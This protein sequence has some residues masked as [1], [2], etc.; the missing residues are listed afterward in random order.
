MGKVKA[1]LVAVSQY[2]INGCSQLPLCRNDLYA[3]R[4]ALIDGINVEPE[5]ILLCGE[6]GIVSVNDLAKII[7]VSMSDMT[8]EDTY[9]FYFSGHG[10]KNFLCLTKELIDLQDFLSH[11]ENVPV[12]NKI[13]IIDSCHSGGFQLDKTPEINIQE[14]IEQFA[15]HGFAV[16]AACGAEEYSG[17]NPNRMISLYT[18]FVCDALMSHS[19][20]R[21]GHKS[22]ESINEAVVRFAEIHNHKEM[23]KPAKDRRIQNPIFRSGIGGTIF[24]DVEKYN[25]YQVEKIYKETDNYIIYSVKPLHSSIA[26]RLAVQVILRYQCTIEQITKIAIE[27]KNIISNCKVYQNKKTEDIYKDKPVNIIF[28]NFGYDEEDVINSNF[29]YNVT[30]ADETQDKNWWYRTGSDT[31]IK[32]DICIQTNTSYQLIKKMQQSDMNDEEFIKLTHEYTINIIQAA[33]QYIKIFREFTNRVISEGELITKGIPLN[34]KISDLFFMNNDLPVAPAHLHD[35][36]Q[37]HDEIISSIHNFSLFYNEKHLSTWDSERRKWLMKN[38]IQ[39]YEIEL[40]KLKK[41]DDLLKKI[42]Y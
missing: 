12:K 9:I 5:N 40:E 41:A 33:E 2:E 11:I 30:W 37:K 25:P 22:L 35:W 10:G 16:M 24:F 38:A 32:N 15:G 42:P 13:A 4:K 29:I 14:T 31:I 39:Q 28:Y 1:V 6:T 34:E 27:I 21:R 17:F 8:K 7:Y 36:S 18:S 3:M 20:I 23:K 26:K 19:L